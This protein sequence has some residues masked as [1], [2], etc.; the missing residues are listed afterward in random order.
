MKTIL[1]VLQ[2]NSSGMFTLA[3]AARFNENGLDTGSAPP[4]PV[5]PAPVPGPPTPPAPSGPPMPDASG[6][7]VSDYYKWYWYWNSVGGANKYSDNYILKTQVVPPVCPTCPNCP[8]C[9]GTCTNCGGNGGSGFVA[10]RYPDTFPLATSTTG[11]PTITTTGGYRIYQ[12]TA[13]GS[14]TF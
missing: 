2:K 11:S 13:S 14:I 10:S 3:N 4:A 6:N 7:A 9:T 8:N 1:F 5:P 12:W